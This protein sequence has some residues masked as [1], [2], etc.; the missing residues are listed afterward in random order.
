LILD[1][2]LDLTMVQIV[3][4]LTAVLESWKNAPTF[5]DLPGENVGMWLSKI[6]L[7][8]KMRG[9]SRQRWT[10]VAMNF[11]SG[12]LKDVLM[13]MRKFM[14]ESGQSEWSW[15]SFETDLTGICEEAKRNRN[16]DIDENDSESGLK[17]FTR[18]HPHLATTAGIALIGTGSLIIAP[19]LALGALNIVGFS[20]IGPV[21]GS[22]AAALQSVIYGGAT[23]GVFSVC[24]S[25]AMTAAVA[26][27]AA[28]T[29][30]CAFITGG[31]WFV[32][33]SAQNATSP[34]GEDSSPPPPPPNK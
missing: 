18:E 22:L 33:S 9:I 32:K 31:T 8:C 1:L 2:N 15:E 19:A 26:S 23:T 6:R 34:P 3:D 14:Q 12:E 4:P 10:D 20:A 5:S 21:A 13:G 17:K 24:Q 29:G 30:A 16:I 11:I 7:G 27:P 25:F 28:I